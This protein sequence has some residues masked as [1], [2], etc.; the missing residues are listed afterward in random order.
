MVASQ[1]EVIC[2]QELQLERQE[3]GEG[4]KSES[5]DVL[6]LVLP[7]WIQPMIDKYGYTAI[8]PS[9]DSL[10]HIASRN[11]RVLGS[12]SAVTNAILVKK[13]QWK[14]LE[15][16]AEE[17]A[18]PITKKNKKNNNSK[19]MQRI[20]SAKNS[21]TMVSV[22][23]E[24]ATKSEAINT[25]DPVVISCVHLDATDERK[26]V[27]QLT[28]CLERSRTLLDH[29]QNKENDAVSTTAVIRPVRAI[30]AGD[31]N[32]EFVPGSCMVA[33]LKEYQQKK[34]RQMSQE[35]TES[36]EAMAEV[37]A[38]TEALR[39]TCAEPPN[40][41]QLQDWRQ[42]RKEAYDLVQD[43]CV[44]LDRVPTG[45]TRCAYEHTSSSNSTADATTQRK[46]QS[47][48]LD[49]LLYT[50]SD[51]EDDKNDSKTGIGGVRPIAYWATLEADSTSCQSGLPSATCPSDHLPIAAVFEIPS[52]QAPTAKENE[53]SVAFVQKVQ[54]FEKRH[55]EVVEQAKAELKA[56]ETELQQKELEKQKEAANKEDLAPVDNNS[57]QGKKK[58]KGNQKRAGPPSTEMMELKR[59]FRSRLKAFQK[60]QAQEREELLRVIGNREKLLLQAHYGI[61]WRKWLEQGPP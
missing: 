31:M 7:E 54:G 18:E 12:D 52:R 14:V 23:L 46:M 28:K 11:L 24:P 15:E 17:D 5:T 8:L 60:N 38:C 19:G 3:K 37:A 36:D 59:E 39:L 48:K 13:D 35:A 57:T 6:P 43:H 45:P 20:Q 55:K 21:N 44:F 56:K 9:Q 40:K 29:N 25:A 26:R 61:P 4:D 53:A 34:K 50:C 42:L 33:T 16:P 2:L 49:H 32:A 1:A 10:D 51:D 22:C 58:K 27:L 30:I 41:E 47:W